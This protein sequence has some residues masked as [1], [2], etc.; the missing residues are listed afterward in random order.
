MREAGGAL[1]IVV[2]ALYVREAAPWR[3]RLLTHSARV[4]PPPRCSAA[5]EASAFYS[6]QRPTGGPDAFAD[7]TWSV[8]MQLNEGGSTIFTM[9]LLEDTSCR[10]SDTEEV[11]SWDCD[12]SWVVV[13]KPK[14]FFEQ[15]LVL[16]AKLQPPNATRPK[17]RLV[18]GLVQSA[19]STSTAAT[20]DETAEVELKDFATFGANEFEE[21]LLA[22]MPRFE[23]E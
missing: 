16:S 2:L 8:L 13:E 7:S 20:D 4:L 19:N 22:T 17:W 6:Y 21:S 23:A 1:L 12:G 14:G 10:F 5:D 11:G 9:Q 15:T 3:V 18:E